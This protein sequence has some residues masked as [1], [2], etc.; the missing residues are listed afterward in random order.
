MALRE[1]ADT[2][3]IV[4]HV[5]HRAYLQWSPVSTA[6][7]MDGH[8]TVIATKANIHSLL[9]VKERG[10]VRQATTQNNLSDFF[11]WL[12]VTLAAGRAKA[13]E[14]RSPSVE[15]VRRPRPLNA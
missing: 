11:R 15:Q 13:G 1:V 4:I 7:G 8:H 9:V 12:R 2:I 6:R 5:T 3:R 14:L 10:R